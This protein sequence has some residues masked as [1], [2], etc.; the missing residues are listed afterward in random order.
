METTKQWFGT[1]KINHMSEEPGGY[2]AMLLG[3]N[4][5]EIPSQE[6]GARPPSGPGSL[7]QDDVHVV[8]DALQEQLAREADHPLLLG[9]L[10]S[11]HQGLEDVGT[12]V[13]IE[14]D[15]ELHT[16]LTVVI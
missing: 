1:L 13:V 4:A 3:Q 5:A 11:P 14:Q 16:G 7:E 8:V 12:A 6:L 15:A 10:Q 2:V 9:S